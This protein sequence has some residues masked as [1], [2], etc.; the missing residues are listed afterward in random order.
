MKEEKVGYT[1]K[2]VLSLWEK[3]HPGSPISRQTVYNWA[4]KFGWTLNKDRV[5]YRQK[6]QID[7]K[8]FDA[9]NANP[10]KFLEKTNEE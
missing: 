1:V 8:L 9:F 3:N 7:A 10:Q 2:E 4:K 6:I 5:L